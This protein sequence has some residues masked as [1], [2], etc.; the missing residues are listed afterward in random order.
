MN[1][2]GLLKLLALLFS[3]GL[4]AAAC[5]GSDDGD[6]GATDTTEA[7]SEEATTEDTVAPA[8][9]TAEEE[10]DT[11][12]EETEGERAYGGSIAVG[13]EAEA[14]GL[15]PW[16]DTC[17]SPC[18]NIMVTI[19]DK[20]VEQTIDGEFE[21]FLLESIEPNEDFTS[22]VGTLRSGVTFHNGTELTAQTIADMFVVQQTGAA[23]AGLIGS[24]NLA[25]VQATGDLEVTYTCLLYTSP[26]PRDA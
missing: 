17:S 22:W 18:Y 24:S 25:D 19:Y 20:L 4:I 14:V 10:V 26:S 13:L 8:G 9:A 7:E 2:Q 1:K 5:G 6:T 23:S 21:G 15:R 16:E 12:V 11:E 3:M